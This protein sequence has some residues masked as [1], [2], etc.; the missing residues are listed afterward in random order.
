[1][2]ASLL[3]HEATHGLLKEKRIPYDDENWQ[4]VEELCSLEEYRFLRRVDEWWADEY[5][6]PKRFN[7]E[8]WRPYREPVAHRAAWRKR[9]EEWRQERLKKKRERER[10]RRH[11][12]LRKKGQRLF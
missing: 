8:L 6:S 5:C 7:P 2:Y 9:F 11:E 3:V 1:M 4:R 10:K 12:L